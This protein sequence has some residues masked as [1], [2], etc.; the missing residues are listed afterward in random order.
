MTKPTLTTQTMAADYATLAR[1]L[2]TLG[3]ELNSTQWY[4]VNEEQRRLLRWCMRH[5]TA[6]EALRGLLVQA[7]S[8]F[9][10]LN[11]AC[12]QHGWPEMFQAF[13]GDGLGVLALLDLALRWEH[14]ATRTTLRARNSNSYPAFRVPAAGAEFYR[15]RGSDQPLVRLRS[16]QNSG[17]NASRR[18]SVWLMIKDRPADGFELIR[19]AEEAMDQ[20]RPELRPSCKVIV[21]MID[22]NVDAELTE[23]LGLANGS[24]QITQARQGLRIRMNEVGARAEVATVA[25]VTKGGSRPAYEFDQPFLG[26]FTQDDRDGQS[27]PLAAFYADYDCWR[28][29][30]S[31]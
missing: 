1:A 22:L 26:W 20:C 2:I 27:V 11:E 24:H 16:V 8:D 23:L 3:R 7:G 29:P 19:T 9:R 30:Q 12:V 25:V 10:S 5:R 4:P 17:P 21:P 31:L 6:V 14:E 18:Q 13:D 28:E 15:L